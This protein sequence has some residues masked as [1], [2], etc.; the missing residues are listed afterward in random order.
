[1]TRMKPITAS[2][3]VPAKRSEL[4]AFILKYFK[5][6]PMPP[7]YRMEVRDNPDSTLT[8]VAVDEQGEI[9]FSLTLGP[10]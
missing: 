5:K 4:L 9:G 3:T 2:F 8:V 7:D 6:N 10:P 1:M